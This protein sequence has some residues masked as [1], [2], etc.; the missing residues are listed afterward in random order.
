MPKDIRRL[1]V[2]LLVVGIPCSGFV[3]WRWLDDRAAERNWA[4]Y[5]AHARSRGVKL[6]AQEFFVRP[7]LS[8]DENYAASP[9]WDRIFARG[10]DVNAIVPE[11]PR[12]AKPPGA[13]ENRNRWDP[14]NL[15]GP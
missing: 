7:D 10:A 3:I 5:L 4:E 8:A 1:V 14:R 13:T 6:S 2:F 15:R 11:L 9:L 12:S